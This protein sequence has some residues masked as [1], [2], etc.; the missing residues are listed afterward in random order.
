MEQAKSGGII[1]IGAS[2]DGKDPVAFLKAVDRSHIDLRDARRQRK[3]DGGSAEAVGINGKGKKAKLALANLFIIPQNIVTL[4]RLDE[5]DVKAV[6]AKSNERRG[7]GFLTA[8]ECRDILNK[9]IIANELRDKYDPEMVT[10]DGPLCD[11]IFRKT[12]K[13]IARQGLTLNQYEES[14]TRKEI[15]TKWLERMDKAHAIVSMPGSAII[16]MKRGS[17]PRVKIFAESRQNRKKFI[18]RVRGLEAY[19]INPSDFAT[20]VSKRFACASV[21][22][23]DPVGREA[24]KK[25]CFELVFQG[26]LVEELQALLTGNE[27]LSSHGGSKNGDYFIPKGVIDVTLKKGVPKKNK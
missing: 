4:M 5:D 21:V 18:T 20:D 13:E 2:K 19:A 22:E 15:N 9:Y 8:P 14:V 24:L 26:H 23:D 11:A 10:L 6:N 3:E 12:K 16:S 17:P 27:Q 7:S 25:G 1:T